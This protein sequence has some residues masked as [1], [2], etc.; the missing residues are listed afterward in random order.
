MPTTQNNSPILT[1]T[2]VAGISYLERPNQ[3]GYFIFPDLSVRHEGRYRLV[4][5]LYEEVKDQKDSDSS[6]PA[7]N[8]SSGD[9]QAHVHG[10]CEVK[11]KI[12]DVFSAKKFPGLAESTHLSRMVADQGCRVRIRRDV[13]LRRRDSK[14]DKDWEAG[15]GNA[16]ADSPKS[17]T[18]ETARPPNQ[19]PHQVQQGFDRPVMNYPPPPTQATPKQ[20]SEQPSYPYYQPPYVQ[21]GPQQGYSPQPPYDP[22]HM[23]QYSAQYLPPPPQAMSQY[24]QSPYGYQH[25]PNPSVP[26]TYML[27][28]THM[29]NQMFDPKNQ[30]QLPQ[31]QQAPHQY[32]HMRH[33]SNQYQPMHPNFSQAPESSP[34]TQTQQ[35]QSGVPL[36]PTQDRTSYGRPPSQSQQTMYPTPA[37]STY[38]NPSSSHSSTG[39]L[40]P[41]KPLPP[42]TTS[43]PPQAKLEPTSPMNATAAG[44]TPGLSELNRPPPPI[45]MS[46]YPSNSGRPRKRGFG[47]VFDTHHMEQPMRD[48]ARPQ[49]DTVGGSD[50]SDGSDEME[51]LESLAMTFRRADGS[52]TRI[53]TDS[54]WPHLK[55]NRL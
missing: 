2:P 10:R 31:S 50:P 24:Q 17:A 42:L 4:F 26:Q 27:P 37:P 48:G 39:T 53:S 44:R 20:E 18:P 3:A 21:P 51:D 16:E 5:T 32:S 43:D 40:M 1:G 36:G 11:S 13:R 22:N 28:P 41:G 14:H 34:Y 33:D 6:Q 35:A 45:F 25:H 46:G 29:Q 7:H 30:Q 19:P 9:T 55:A 38:S 8:Q 15:D 12:F 52:F 54:S 49:I 23:Q 47:S